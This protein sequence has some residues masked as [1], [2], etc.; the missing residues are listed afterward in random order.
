MQLPDA[1]FFLA[2]NEKRNQSSLWYRAAPLGENSIGGIVKGMC[3]WAGISGG[4]FVN[5][6]IRKRVAQSLLNRGVPPHIISQLTGHKNPATLN[7]YST[8][9]VAVQHSMCHILTYTNAGKIY[10]Y[11]FAWVK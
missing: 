2:V 6:S 9:P 10:S 11:A 7:Q 8:A 5:Y 1:P 3:G 4:N